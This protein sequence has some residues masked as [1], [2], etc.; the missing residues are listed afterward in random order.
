MK[1]NTILSNKM[2]KH[3]EWWPCHRD[4]DVAVTAAVATAG[5]P[6][7]LFLGEGSN[8]CPTPCP[9]SRRVRAFFNSA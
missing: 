4:S 1:M 6:R 2:G 7:T 5:P 8:V 9:L 3:E